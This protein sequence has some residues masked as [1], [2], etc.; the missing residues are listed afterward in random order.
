MSVIITIIG[1]IFLLFVIVASLRILYNVLV[2]IFRVW[3]GKDKSNN[4]CC[5]S[6]FLDD[7]R[8]RNNID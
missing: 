2:G 8:K 5:G 1:F 3:T 7:Y 4:V 6:D